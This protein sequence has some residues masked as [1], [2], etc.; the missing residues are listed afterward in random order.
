V[1]DEDQKTLNGETLTAKEAGI[2]AELIK[3]NGKLIPKEF[4]LS[5]VWGGEAHGED[6]YIEVYMSRLRKTMRKAGVKTQVKTSRGLG[7]KLV[8][9]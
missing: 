7:Y 1:F 5:K 3:A 4:L 6:N 9:A 2:I 8:E